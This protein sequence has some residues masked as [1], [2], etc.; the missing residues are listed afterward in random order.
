MDS[1][2]WLTIRWKNI[3]IKEGDTV[4]LHS[5]VMRTLVLMK[6]EGYKPLASE[7]LESFMSAVGNSGTLIIPLFNFGFAKG[8]TFDFRKTKS[9]MGVLTECARKR[10][11][12]V[13]TGH[14]VYSFAVLGFNSREFR[15]LNNLSGYGAD[16]P[17]GVLRRLKGKVAALDLEDD[18]CMTFYHHVEEMCKVSYRFKKEFKG[19]YVDENGKESKRSYFIY[20][21]DLELGVETCLN[22]M[23]ENLW[24]A[25]I[26]RGH[27]PNVNSGLR[28]AD[29]DLMFDYVQN[30]IEDGKAL[31]NLYTLNK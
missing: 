22:P 31:G 20:V 6:R 28:I 27:K 18:E 3:G 25:G 1:V 15:G 12:A 4:L 10:K 30:M 14:P 8:S 16:S 17:F 23:G 5:D 29:A 9:H 2:E 11:D 26:Y 19:I 7:I 21:R 13:R 24:N